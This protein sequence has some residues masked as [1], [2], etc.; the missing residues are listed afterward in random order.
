[1]ATKNKQSGGSRLS[2]TMNTDF[3]TV[4]IAAEKLGLQ[5]ATVRKYYSSG[6][7]KGY[8]QAGRLYF[9]HS[10]LIQFITAE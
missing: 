3:Y 1:M 2:E 6:K 9:L 5:P 7:I 8:K 4:E 10:D